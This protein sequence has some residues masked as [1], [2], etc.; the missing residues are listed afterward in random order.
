MTI[1]FLL[2]VLEQFKMLRF[3]IV[4]VFLIIFIYF[5]LT[6][7]NI[8]FNALIKFILIMISTLVSDITF[9]DGS[10][11]M[12]SQHAEH[13]SF[14]Y[15]VV[16]TTCYVLLIHIVLLIF[17]HGF[18]NIQNYRWVRVYLHI[19]VFHWAWFLFW[20]IISVIAHFFKISILCCFTL[21]VL[22][23]GFLW[24][25]FPVECRCLAIQKLTIYYKI[26]FNI[27]HKFTV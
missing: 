19:I 2:D 25:V 1:F 21:T 24:N 17:L 11:V 10:T 16:Q 22:I 6:M 18:L 14:F 27:V 23:F 13:M 12:I 15:F 5:F 8:K 20:F 3:I 9:C 4:C 26:F 7:L